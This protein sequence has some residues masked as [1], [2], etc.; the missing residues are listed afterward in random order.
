MPSSPTP[1]PDLQRTA[2]ITRA[3]RRRAML[4]RLAEMGMAMAEEICQRSIEGPYHPEPRQDAGRSFAAVARAVRLT[5]TL[6]ARVDDR[7][8]ALRNGVA[9]SP[10]PWVLDAAGEL[11]I[12]APSA[13]AVRHS[14]SG[15]DGGEQAD[16]DQWKP[17]SARPTVSRGTFWMRTVSRR[18][19]AR[20]PALA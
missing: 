15:D 18:A 9:L 13:P 16:A 8:F 1:C 17:S 3:E 7:I 4:E 11:R 6:E 19:E 20:A 12:S 2:A 10:E 14:D 5:L